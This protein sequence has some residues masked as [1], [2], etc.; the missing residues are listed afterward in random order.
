MMEKE[1][2]KKKEE[3]VE[4]EEEEEVVV[5][6]MKKEVKRGS[7]FRAQIC[8]IKPTTLQNGREEERQGRQWKSRRCGCGEAR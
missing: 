2:T 8:A 1:R 6:G 5:E 4:E 7:I 3:E